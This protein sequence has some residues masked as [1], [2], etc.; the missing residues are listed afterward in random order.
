[1]HQVDGRSLLSE[2]KFYESYSR[3]S[4]ELGRYETW[5]ES[6][7]RVMSMHRKKYDSVMSTELSNLI[8]EV[9]EAYKD[10]L[11]LG[12]QRS[13]QFGGEQILKHNMRLYNCTSTYGDR[14][15]FFGEFFFILLCFAP[16]TE[17]ITSTGIKQIKD[18]TVNDSVLSFNEQDRVYEFKKVLAHF[19]TPSENRQKIELKFDNDHIVKCT[20]DHKFLT[21]NR[22]WVEAQD[23]EID[24]ELENIFG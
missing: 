9:T 10:K 7:D 16:E 4:E 21:K 3:Y 20:A 2:T 24:D 18:V 6:V 22:G 11:V 14:P 13:L 12:A 23:L 5:E 17:I 19:E 8:D 1:M 15:A